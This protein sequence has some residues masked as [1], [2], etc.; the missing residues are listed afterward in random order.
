[1]IGSA[2]Y[3]SNAFLS[4]IT[5]KIKLREKQLSSLRGSAELRSKLDLEEVQTQV[6][7]AK[8]GHRDYC[9]YNEVL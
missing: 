6:L 3:H 8:K 9:K 5:R 4:T 7:S 1:M 2:W